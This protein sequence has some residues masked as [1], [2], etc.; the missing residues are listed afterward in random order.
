MKTVIHH[1]PGRCEEYVRAI[2][3]VFPGTLVIEENVKKPDQLGTYR[4]CLIDEPH[5]HFENDVFLAP[6]FV[7]RAKAM[8]KRNHQHMCKGFEQ[9]LKASGYYP[10]SHWHWNQCVWF[11]KGYGPKIAE[12]T[13][14]Y[15]KIKEP[16][17]D[18]DTVIRY[19]LTGRRESF[20][21][22]SPSLVQHVVGPSLIKGRL[23][24]R[25]SESFNQA[26]P[27]LAV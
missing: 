7:E 11:P 4:R 27:D 18:Y 12:Y 24:R 2:L 19:F 9:K 21:L 13:F 17:Y 26:Y 16:P 20:W 22:E 15:A 1:Y 3:E 10:P 5:M 23:H 25:V 6:D 8:I 14:E